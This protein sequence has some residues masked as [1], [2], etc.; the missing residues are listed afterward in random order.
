V[1]T[2]IPS[3]HIY[4]MNINKH[5]GYK[6]TK[7]NMIAHI[8]E[9]FNKMDWFI[10]YHQDKADAGLIEANLLL[11]NT[12]GMDY[13]DYNECEGMRKHKGHSSIVRQ[14]KSNKDLLNEILTEITGNFYGAKEEDKQS[15]EGVK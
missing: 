9:R 3:C 13:L 2:F 11:D 12:E 14:Y 8:E 4:S 6:M 5:K 10:A 1:G 15:T 7:K